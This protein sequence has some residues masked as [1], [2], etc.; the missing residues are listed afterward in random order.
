MTLG[1]RLT[2]AEAAALIQQK[3]SWLPPSNRI[4]CTQSYSEGATVSIAS[5]W[6]V[7]IILQAYPST[8]IANGPP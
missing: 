1:V 2:P 4:Q 7:Y 3:L 6:D 8:S 5:M